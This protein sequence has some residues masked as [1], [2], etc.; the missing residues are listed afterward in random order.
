MR[1]I[2][3]DIGIAAS[4][5]PVAVDKAAVDLV[6]TTAGKKLAKL[7][8]ND[9]LEPGYQFEHA[10]RIGLGSTNYELIEVN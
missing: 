2:V 7:L 4:T 9:K 6:E 8:G 10:Q 5:D 1:K 3:D